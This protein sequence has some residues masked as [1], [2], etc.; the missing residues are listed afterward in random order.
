MI[1]EKSQNFKNIFSKNMFFDLVRFFQPKMFR[2][3]FRLI[4]ST[5]HFDIFVD[6]TFSRQFCFGQ[7]CFSKHK[8]FES[9]LL[10]G[11]STPLRPHMDRALRAKPGSRHGLGHGIAL[12]HPHLLSALVYSVVLGPVMDC[13]S[14]S[15]RFQ[16]AVRPLVG[17]GDSG[18]VDPL[19]IQRLLCGK[20]GSGRP[21]N[22]SENGPYQAFHNTG[23]G[24][25]SKTGLSIIKPKGSA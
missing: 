24:A 23:W 18:L 13:R 9:H 5:K 17:D 19:G 8:N 22:S 20:L 25:G 21:D 14:H 10:S 15:Q 16:G 7:F 11:N 12:S 3:F 6:Q 4:F 1:F 2:S